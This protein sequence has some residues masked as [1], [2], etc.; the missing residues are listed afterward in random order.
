M[1]DATSA[2]S[3]VGHLSF[4]LLGHSCA[5]HVP[6]GYSASVI[7]SSDPFNIAYPFRCHRDRPAA[8]E[9]TGSKPE[10]E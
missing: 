3:R 4:T 7:G 9:I 1:L 2:T 6:R 10:R 8:R 5:L